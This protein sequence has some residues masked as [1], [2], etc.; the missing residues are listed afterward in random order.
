MIRGDRVSFQWVNAPCYK[1]GSKILGC[2]NSNNLRQ[3]S[4]N[5][6]QYHW[7]IRYGLS[8]KGSIEY[9]EEQE[10]PD[11]ET[12]FDVWSW[13]ALCSS[14]CCRVHSWEKVIIADLLVSIKVRNVWGAVCG[15][16]ATWLLGWEKGQGY[17]SLLCGFGTASLSSDPIWV[18]PSFLFMLFPPGNW[19]FWSE[20]SAR[21]PN[22]AK[23]VEPFPRFP[24]KKSGGIS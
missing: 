20:I 3:W 2:K 22:Y 11:S 10:G 8:M 14:L 17:T 5:L 12:W 6:E 18:F 7:N 15:S 23:G 21:F 9:W 24:V 19:V 1:H 4:F 16:G 13:A